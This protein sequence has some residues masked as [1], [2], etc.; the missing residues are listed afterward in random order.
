MA[1][2]I[3]HVHVWMVIRLNLSKVKILFLPFG[4]VTGSLVITSYISRV[5]CRQ[6]YKT[7]E[8]P[9]LA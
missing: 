5:T 1:L 4:T 2:L 6:N 9:V 7:K 3:V 8:N